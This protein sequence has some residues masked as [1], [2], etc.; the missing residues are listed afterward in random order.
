MVHSTYSKKKT[1][2]VT[3]DQSVGGIAVTDQILQDNLLINSLVPDITG[4]P[5]RPQKEI[6]EEIKLMKFMEK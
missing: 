3:S 5:P 4:I 2:F 6:I 1:D